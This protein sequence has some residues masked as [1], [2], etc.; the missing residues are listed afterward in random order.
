MP[1][2]FVLFGIVYTAVFLTEIVG[3]RS[4]YTIGG[5]VTRFGPAQVM[6]GISA[7][8]GLK[9]LLAVALG[10]TL[11]LLPAGVIRAL[12]IASLVGAAAMIWRESRERGAGEAP[13]PACGT[14]PVLVA[15]A[16]VFFIEWADPGQLAAAMLSARYHAPAVVWA[17]ATAALVTKGA[18]A[19]TLGVA[20]RRWVPRRLLTRLAVV[21][22]L[23]LALAV[24]AGVAT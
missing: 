15:F 21:T 8:F 22:L 6:G 20:V 17:A 10:E 12:A 19:M 5:L 13:A 16:A 18:L 4:L 7:A 1:G 24:A 14:H 3:D 23:S 2:P 9:M 11:A